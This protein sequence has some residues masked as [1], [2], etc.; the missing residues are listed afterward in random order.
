MSRK[1]MILLACLGA[2]VFV[3]GIV[4]ALILLR[5]FAGGPVTVSS[6]G[7][8]SPPP[9]P[10]Q[11]TL[12]VV[13]TADSVPSPTAVG[14]AQALADRLHC[15]PKCLTQQYTDFEVDCI[16]NGTGTRLKALNT[17]EAKKIAK[18]LGVDC[19]VALRLRIAERDVRLDAII[20]R[21]KPKPGEFSVSLSGA[22]TDLP[23]LQADLANRVVGVLGLALK[24]DQSAEIKKPNFSNPTALALYGKSR[25]AHTM[26]EAESL[27]KK[28]LEADPNS[29][30]ANLQF[31]SLYARGPADY[32]DVRRARAV[33]VL[34]R[35]EKQWPGNSLV[36]SLRTPLLVKL[37]NY[38]DAEKTAIKLVRSDPNFALAHNDLSAVARRRCDADLAVL[39]GQW[40]TALW[41][42]N[43]FAHSALACGYLL[44]ASNA[45]CGHYYSEMSWQTKR[46][47][48]SAL[49]SCVNEA[50]T[51]IKLFPRCGP[52]WRTLIITG[53]ELG[54]PQTQ[55]AFEAARES[56]PNDLSA[57]VEYGFSLSPQWGGSQQAEMKVVGFARERFG[58]NSPQARVVEAAIM[59]QYAYNAGYT[60]GGRYEDDMLLPCEWQDRIERDLQ[61][62]LALV[63]CRN[64]VIARQRAKVYV[65][66]KS[67]FETWHSL[68]WQNLYGMGCSFRYEDQ[69]DRKALEKA[70]ELFAG[71]AR[72]VPYETSFYIRWGWCLSHLGN[73]AAAKA[74]FL[75]ALELD[76][77]NDYAK[78]KLQY[79]Q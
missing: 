26:A 73:P 79:V 42:S 47:W 49:E 69:Q 62:S 36:R 66:A 39:E 60:L 67:G 77:L 23:K 38:E 9:E 71:C 14:F 70:C 12:A 15:A 76:P 13:A 50:R 78:E 30:F 21:A 3:S 45:R 20:L 64:H 35:A 29:A 6:H 65:A 11:P 46:K 28:M 55:K 8:P 24:P 57:Y 63:E 25:V 68:I 18:C 74:K 19:L 5:H 56:D 44:T 72:Q 52:A 51:A 59:R 1:I 40:Y 61:Q 4:S 10:S 2:A 33:S 17:T 32:L 48:K 41:P 31:V 27:R 54:D 37:Y 7:L 16:L 43:P 75:K 58:T 34:A 53:R 22:E